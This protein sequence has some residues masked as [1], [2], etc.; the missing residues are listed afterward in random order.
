[1]TLGGQSD[2][3]PFFASTAVPAL[4]MQSKDS[5][6]A[7]CGRLTFQF[8]D[9]VVVLL[10]GRTL[11]GEPPLQLLVLRDCRNGSL[12]QLNSL[13]KATLRGS[14]SRQGFQTHLLR[15]CR[16]IACSSRTL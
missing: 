14:E 8:E 7:L 6:D 3:R 9:L 10:A 15:D 4:N 12:Q 1:M 13:E 11:Q 2:L 5:S 16:R